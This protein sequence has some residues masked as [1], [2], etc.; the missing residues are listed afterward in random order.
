MLRCAIIGCGSVAEAYHQELQKLRLK[1]LVELTWLCDHREE[2]RAVL[3]A[4]FGVR[5]Y[6]A[7]YRELLARPDVDAVLLLTPMPLHAHQ[8]VQALRAGKHVL[9]EKPLGTTLAEARAVVAAAR[10]ARGHLIVAPFVTLSETYR[11]ISQ[12]VRA[13]A[14]GTVHSAQGLYGWAGPDWTEWFYRKGGGALFDLGVYNLSAITGLLGPARRVLA[15]GGVAVPRRR[16]GKRWVKP[17]E[18]DLL[19]VTLDFGAARF[20]TIV[21]GFT[22]QRSR[23]PALELYGT[24]GTIQMLGEVWAPQGF[25]MWRNADG[26]W[27]VFPETEPLWSWTDGLKHLAECVRDGRRPALPLDHAFHVAEIM[28]AAKAAVRT[29]RAVEVRS[30][31]APLKLARARAVQAHLV[32]DPGREEA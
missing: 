8:A 3:T 20:A 25:E 1:G 14:I 23:R 21:C 5:N 22:I 26:C 32:H 24:E 12:L 11:R 13:G 15:A 10:R 7:D 28:C 27:K 30:R 18:A 9:V 29:G 2:K 16:I 19:H 17:A 6:T 31:F 4:K